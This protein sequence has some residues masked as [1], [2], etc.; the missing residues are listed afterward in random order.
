MQY[1]RVR[2]GWPESKH[3]L[4]S[5]KLESTPNQSSMIWE[6][7]D[8]CNTFSEA[9]KRTVKELGNIELY[10]LGEISKTI[11]CPTCLR[12]PMEGTVYC[13]SGV[14]LMP[15]PEQTRKITNR[16]ETMSNPFYSIKKRIPEDQ[17][18]DLSN[19]SNDHWKAKDAKKKDAEADMTPSC[20]DGIQTRQYR[21]SQ[22]N[23]GWTEEYCRYLDYLLTV[24]IKY[25]AT[26][27]ERSRYHNMLVL[28]LQD[29]KD[30]VKMSKRDDF[31]LAAR[32]LVILGHQEGRGNLHL[33]KSKKERQV[34]ARWVTSIRPGVA[35]LE[36]SK[37]LWIAGI[38]F[39]FGNLV[40][41][42]R[43]ARTTRLAWM[44]GMA[45]MS[46]ASVSRQSLCKILAHS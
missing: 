34:T 40:G 31:N 10:E 35:K 30:S 4:I 25:I 44:A 12:Y 8:T 21:E 43:M 41:T 11:Q 9:S 20:I 5:C 17:D 16:F 18:T 38:I 23:I 22:W 7:K 26:W 32:S 45:R 2:T 27:P 19:G 29:G 3:W 13:T 42:S 1:T 37:I 6:R 36:L 39:I 28:K 24:D 46:T 15:L 33:P 14:C